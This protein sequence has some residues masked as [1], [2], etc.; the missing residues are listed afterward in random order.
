MTLTFFTFVC[1]LLVNGQGCLPEG[2]EFVN[3]SQI[4]NFQLNYP[5]CT[6]IEGD[7]IIDGWEGDITDL[8]GLNTISKIDGSFY[9]WDCFNLESL[10]G[11]ENIDTIL[12]WFEIHQNELLVNLQGLNGLK[13]VGGSLWIYTNEG[14]IS[15]DGLEGLCS[16]GM[17]LS[18]F[19][20]D[21]LASLGC[22]NNLS[23]INGLLNISV[24]F[25]LTSLSGLD[26]I[27]P[28]SISELAITNNPLLTSCEVQSIC[29]YLSLPNGIITIELN[30]QGCSS[31]SQV[32]DACENVG[33]EDKFIAD[34]IFVFPNPTSG[35]VCIENSGK[36]EITGIK[37][38]DM[39]GLQVMSTYKH[40]DILIGQLNAGQYIIE[41]TTNKSVFRKKLLVR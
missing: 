28:A 31:P 1:L 5:N 18:I 33:Y 10:S 11:L 4:D 23:E 35:R 21:N 29:D 20:N 25:K 22:L 7:V 24:N 30:A 36:E 9:I 38:Y 19:F 40:K 39:Q 16:V 37:I 34:N 32:A 14:L 41:I 8:S 17:G 3:Q 2:I 15:L 26:N 13:H 6:E 27:A 12:G